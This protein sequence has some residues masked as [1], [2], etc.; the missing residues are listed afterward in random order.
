MAEGL[1]RAHETDDVGRSIIKYSTNIDDL[2]RVS[3]IIE[4][5]KVTVTI[6]S[7]RDTFREQMCGTVIEWLN[8]IA[9]CSVGPDHDIFTPGGL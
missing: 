8:D 4:Q 1:K 6:R 5:I 9:G 7:A 2:L 3:S